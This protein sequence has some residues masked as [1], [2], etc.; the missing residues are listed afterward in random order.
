MNCLNR[1][2]RWGVLAAIGLGLLLEGCGDEATQPLTDPTFAISA[3]SAPSNPSAVALA[4][5]TVKVTW[6]DNSTN[7]SGFQIHRSTTGLSGTYSLRATRPANARAFRDAKVAPLTSYCYKIRAFR[8]LDG[9]TRYSAF[10]SAVCAKTPAAPR[11]T[12]PS[13]TAVK[14]ASSTSVDVS[15]TD[16]SSNETGFRVKR[17][18]DGGSTWTTAAT[19]GANVTAYQDGG[20]GPEQQVCYRV[21]A[22]N[23]VGASSSDTDCTTPPAAPTNL[24]AS[25]AAQGGINLTWA[26]N[27]SAE[28]GYQVQ[29]SGDG[30]TYSTI[31]NLAA[32]TTS[33][34]DAGTTG[35]TTYSYRVQAKKDGGFSDLSNVATAQGVPPVTT[36]I[37][38]ASVVDGNAEVYVINSDG[39]G[40]QRLTSNPAW[41]GEPAWSPD[42]QR[43]A[44][45]SERDGALEIYV[46]NADGSNVTRLTTGGGSKPS[47]SP[48]GTRI[49]FARNYEIYTMNSDGTNLK[50][51]TNISSA[52][53][54]A[55][56]P[57]WSPTGDKVAFTQSG[58]IVSLIRTDGSGLIQLTGGADPAWSSDGTKLA[59]S[60]LTHCPL[61]PPDC[62]YDIFVINA[63]GSGETQVTQTWWN[64]YTDP[65][66]SLDGESIVAV[67]ADYRDPW[68]CPECA[69]P[70]LTT[71]R[72]SGPNLIPGFNPSWRQ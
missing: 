27:S 52:T 6:S 13:G 3:P 41:D 70:S 46:M 62:W 32:N 1:Q 12:A 38:Y 20:R 67:Y 30:T 54:W 4:F 2:W 64:A 11:P 56:S 26:D 7:E 23:A 24:V 51:L 47:W 17:S 53:S 37:A 49:A 42:R 16:K 9:E 58:T 29:R 15:W 14:P 35:N 59:F 28:D 36:Q 34:G 43:L 5:D 40:T 33:Y 72:G 22:F 21:V 31:T 44:F 39:S 48:D 10:T 68:S 66:W 55:A 57:A 60:R 65:T 69:L 61:S 50:Q 25:A 18:L 63:D 8:T 19:V 45:T 71:I